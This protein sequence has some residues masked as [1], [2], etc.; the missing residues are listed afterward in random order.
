MGLGG[1]PPIQKSK[2]DQ[3]KKQPADSKA[4]NEKQQ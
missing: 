1:A 3:S 2:S 4:K